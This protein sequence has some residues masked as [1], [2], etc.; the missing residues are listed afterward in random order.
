MP[1]LGSSLFIQLNIKITYEGKKQKTTSITQNH[2][3]TKTQGV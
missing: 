3:E 1:P 2:R